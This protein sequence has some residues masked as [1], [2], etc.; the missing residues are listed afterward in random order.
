MYFYVLMVPV[1]IGSIITIY[2][3]W[4]LKRHDEVL[5]RF[6]RVRRNAMAMLR[7]TGLDLTKEEYV[8]LREFVESLSRIIHD[9]NDQKAKMFDLKRSSAH[10]EN[11][12]VLAEK[13]KQV[14]LSGNQKISE[15]GHQFQL[16]VALAFFRYTPIMTF[17]VPIA[18][19]VFPYI[20]K[21]CR[22]WI[23]NQARIL[24]HQARRAYDICH[25]H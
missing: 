16:A 21:F 22:G 11:A 20:A 7:E 12:E 25:L 3:L 17:I 2:I 24:F 8:F 10:F 13:I 15:L 18:M 6:C 5:F 23:S 9:Y 19:A 1:L 4:N 14:G